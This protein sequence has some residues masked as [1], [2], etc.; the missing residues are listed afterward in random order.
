MP[1][2]FFKFLEFYTL[3]IL[4]IALKDPQI[5]TH[6]LKFHFICIKTSQIIHTD[7]NK[8]SW[9]SWHWSIAQTKS[10]YH[11]LL[12]VIRIFITWDHKWLLLKVKLTSTC[13]SENVSSKLCYLDSWH[14]MFALKTIS[15]F[16]HADKTRMSIMG[17]DPILHPNI[18]RYILQHSRCY[19]H[20]KSWARD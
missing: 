17:V 4:W 20:K 12:L 19:F 2:K 15:L 6:M 9:T 3:R 10:Y 14:V 13:Y 1:L 11:G 7:I 18:G 16:D 5:S 8:K